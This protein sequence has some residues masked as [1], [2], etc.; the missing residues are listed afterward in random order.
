[1]VTIINP[2]NFHVSKAN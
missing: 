1:M 2:D